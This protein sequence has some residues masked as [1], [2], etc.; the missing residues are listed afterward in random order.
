VPAY[1]DHP[2]GQCALSVCGSRQ[3]CDEPDKFFETAA[4]EECGHVTD[5]ARQGCNYMPMLDIGGG[6]NQEM[7]CARSLLSASDRAVI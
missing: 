5:I 3:T 7:F 1:K 2:I 6:R 4:C